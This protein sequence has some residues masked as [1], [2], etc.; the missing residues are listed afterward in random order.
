MKKF[1]L[2][3][4]YVSV[5]PMALFAQNGVTVS[6]LAVSNGSPST[7]TFDVSWKDTGMQPVWSDTVWVWVDYNN[8]GV[9]ERLPLVTSSATLTATS[10][11][12]VGKVV[13]VDGNIQGVWVVGDARDAGAFSATV[14]LVTTV[15]EI[16][17]ACAY[18]SNYPPVGKY[19]SA[20]EIEFTGT[21]G[22]D[23]V[24]VGGATTHTESNPYTVSA[25]STVL[26][27]TDKT[28]AP[29]KL[30]CRPSATY[31]LTAS[32]AAYCTGSTVTFALS[33]TASGRTYWLY[34]GAEHVN[35]LTGTGGAATFTGAFAGVGV[36]TAQV[37]A[38]GGNCPAVMHGTHDVSENP[39]PMATASAATICSG[40]TAALTA[41]ASAG[42][43]SAMTYTWNIGGTSS[44]TSVNSTTSQPLTTTTTYTVQLTN[45]NGC[46][47]NVSEPATITVNPTAIVSAATVCSGG[48][49]TLSAILGAGTTTAMTYTW[50]IGGTSSTTSV[51]SKTSQ[52]L[53]TSTTYTVQLRTSNGCVG[54]VSAPAT[55]TV[56]PLPAATVT[57]KT[58]CSGG[59]VT[60][61]ATLGAGTTTAMTYTWTI[62]RTSSTTSVNS[63][64]SQTL[65]AN[66]TYTVRL[67]N[68]DG[69]VGVVSAP[70][71]ITVNTTPTL[72]FST[73]LADQSVIRGTNVAPTTYSATNATSISLSSGSFPSGVNSS[74]VLSG[75]RVY[76]G[77]SGAPSATGNYTYQLTATNSGCQ[78]API[79]GSI[80]VRTHSTTS[81]KFK[82]ST[83][84]SQCGYTVSDY[85][86][87]DP[88]NCKLVSYLSSTQPAQ[89]EYAVTAAGRYYYSWT[90]VQ[91][92]TTAVCTSPW[93]MASGADHCNFR[94]CTSSNTLPYE[95]PYVWGPNGAWD[96]GGRSGFWDGELGCWY[97][98]S[99]NRVCLPSMITYLPGENRYGNTGT[100]MGA[101]IRCVR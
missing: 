41:T 61:S 38:E 71:T 21:P 97:C 45:S 23:L 100:Q 94:N 65:T 90:C 48:T 64:T 62:G 5:I 87:G 84:W 4:I 50:N 10:A 99:T 13:P 68:A 31:N 43:T 59:T 75:S 30:G 78:S 58:I 33:N 7:V 20:T 42:T 54:A 55:I 11:V 82:S 74:S 93:R 14:R 28:G 69:C 17:G 96:D 67:T 88:S 39:L 47:G 37:I 95:P 46:V 15:T 16:G 12:G 76:F 35:T 57:A 34:K 25:G 32:A 6:N 89:P 92:I 44:T 52:T 53:T 80:A 91:L 9:M 24:F 77:I 27:F 18:A 85:V 36:Y 51:N 29:G 98:G 70:A 1:L 66:T 101:S 8:N 26:S 72:T 63:K 3:I 40:G 83:T 56:N 49:V 2:T 81:Y 86:V 60:L 19:T 73:G 22:Y 79:T